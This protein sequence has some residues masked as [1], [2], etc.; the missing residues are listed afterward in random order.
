[1]GNKQTV[2][3]EEQLENYAVSLWKK[4]LVTSNSNITNFT[5]QWKYVRYN[6][7]IVITVIISVVNSSFWGLKYVKNSFVIAVISL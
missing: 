1:M 4:I 7:D 3:S 6:R 5:G 2:F